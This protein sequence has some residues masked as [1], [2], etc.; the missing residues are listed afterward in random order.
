[1]KIQKVVSSEPEIIEK[2]YD[3]KMD[4][5]FLAT[6]GIYDV[7]SNKKIIELIWGTIE[8]YRGKSMSM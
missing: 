7:L 2:E 3:D 4:F 5:A 1:M 8:Y 6:D